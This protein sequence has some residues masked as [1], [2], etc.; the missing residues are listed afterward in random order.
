MQRFNS[1]DFTDSYNRY[2]SDRIRLASELDNDFLELED[3]TYKTLSGTETFGGLFEGLFESGLAAGA[4]GAGTGT[5]LFPG[6]GT[7][8]GGFLGFVGGV[9]A[10]GA[11]N[12][13]KVFNKGKEREIANHAA[14]EAAQRQRGEL[15][16][17]FIES[18]RQKR[19]SQFRFN[20]LLSQE[21]TLT[22]R[23]KN[24]A[25]SAHIN[26]QLSL[27]R[28]KA[29]YLNKI[30]QLQ[31]QD[32]KATNALES[33]IKLL[34]DSKRAYKLNKDL[35]FQQFKLDN[36]GFKADFNVITAKYQMAGLAKNLQALK[37][38]ELRQQQA[39]ALNSYSSGSLTNAQ[40]I[41][42]SS[43]RSLKEISSGIE[44]ANAIEQ[45]SLKNVLDYK[46]AVADLVAESTKLNLEKGALATRFR[47]DLLKLNS[48]ARTNILKLDTNK[49][50]L[51]V[52]LEGLALQQQAL[53]NAFSNFNQFYN[54]RKRLIDAELETD[55]TS[56]S[57]RF[58][59]LKNREYENYMSIINN[60]DKTIR[61]TRNDLQRIITGLNLG[62]TQAVT[63][64]IAS[65][66]NTFTDTAKRLSSILEPQYQ[67]D[68]PYLGLSSSRPTSSFY[69]QYDYGYPLGGFNV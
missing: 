1:N 10:R 64:S 12:I 34:A 26:L 23:Y 50:A 61:N 63:S 69:P 59:L 68:N 45:R 3:V 58:S 4:V 67:V 20:T 43:L 19:S 60:E 13:W 35:L 54:A 40:R 37:I 48:T 2:R 57:D 9:A 5:F 39:L 18:D 36:Q 22:T 44:L 32:L 52:T 28:E 46:N 15:K 56:A 31:V 11:L 27:G 47:L 24:K 21:K 53:G 17:F 14:R 55:L 25:A 29:S 41:S 16:E 33:T 6:L 42:Q 49:R 66:G 51:E 7:V 38:A 62:N 65:L 30:T 8:G